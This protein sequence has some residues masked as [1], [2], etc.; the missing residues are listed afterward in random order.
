MDK[1]EDNRL[2]FVVKGLPLP[3]EFS[4]GEAAKSQGLPLPACLRLGLTEGQSFRADL[5]QSSSVKVRS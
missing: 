2:L 3:G 1:G 4:P 5:R